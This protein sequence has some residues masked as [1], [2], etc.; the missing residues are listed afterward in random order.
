MMQ[1]AIVQT[2]RRKGDNP[3]SKKIAYSSCRPLPVH[4]MS[5]H[6]VMGLFVDDLEA[7]LTVLCKEGLVTSEEAF[8]AEMTISGR[9]ELPELVRKF[10]ESGIYCTFGDVIDSI[11]Q[12]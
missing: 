11:Y 2:G 4:Y 3:Y 8:G 6:S 1:I 7:A 10:S 12:G 5:E 9:N